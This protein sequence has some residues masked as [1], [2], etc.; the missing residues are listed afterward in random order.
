MTRMTGRPACT[1]WKE[2][3]S[4]LRTWDLVGPRCTVLAQFFRPLYD[5]DNSATTP[6]Q[7]LR[8]SISMLDRISGHCLVVQ[9]ASHPITADTGEGDPRCG[10]PLATSINFAEGTNKRIVAICPNIRRLRFKI[11]SGVVSWHG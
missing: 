2:G 8:T 6:T 4:I 5:F 11:G 3:I 10:Y 7:V 1:A 9:E